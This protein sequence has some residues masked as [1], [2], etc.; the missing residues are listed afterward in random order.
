MAHLQ[1]LAP[2]FILTI[3]NSDRDIPLSSASASLKKLLRYVA[4]FFFY[5]LLATIATYPLILKAAD[6]VFGQ[7][8]PMLNIWAMAWVNHQLPQDAWHLFG[9]NVFYPYPRT[10]AFS[11]HLFV[12]ALMASPWIAVTGNPVLAYN[13]VA[14]LTL[15]LAGLGMYLF[16]RELTNHPVA[17]FVGGLLY[18][19]STWNINELSRIQ[20][21]SNQWFPFLLWALVRFFRQPGQK[22]AF[23]AGLASVLQALSCMYWALYLP[24]VVLPALV[25]LQWRHDLPWR[26][27]LPLGWNL[28]GAALLTAL[29][30]IPYVQN[31]RTFEFTRDP[32][33]PVP[34]D[35]Y[36]QVNRENFLYQ[37]VLGTARV[38]E[39]AA[40]FLGFMAMLLG[41]VGLFAKGASPDNGVRLYRPLFIV[42]IVAGF[43]LSLGHEIRWGN[44]RIAPGPYAAL[45][46]WVPGFRN[47]R[48]PERF[49]IL[50]L[51]G[52]APMVASALTLLP[53]NLSRMGVPLLGGFLFLEHLSVPLDLTHL[54]TGDAMPSVYRWI[55]EDHDIGV[56]A[57]VPSTRYLGERWDMDGMYYSTVHWRRTLQGW[58]SFNPP[59]FNTI[60]WRMFHFP[61]EET[62][63]LLEKLGVDAIVVRPEADDSLRQSNERWTRIGPFPEGHVVLR[64]KRSAGM[65]F[66]PPEDSR[67]PLVNLDPGAWRLRSSPPGPTEQ[68]IDRNLKTS[69]STV[70]HQ[71]EHHYFAVHFSSLRKPRLLTMRAPTQYG[72]PMRFE[73]LGLLEDRTWTRLPFDRAS[74]YDRFF[75][76]LLY[77]PSAARLEVELDAPPVWEILIRITETDAFQMPWAIRELRI[78]EGA[79]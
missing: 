2:K 35:R 54:P 9:G 27:L 30:A 4:P 71:K 77:E 46:E 25:V 28:A 72:F 8:G 15:A 13:M 43:F 42:F 62:V 59:I 56:I 60:R 63:T 29:F 67:S 66:R 44:H 38:N 57:E 68:A 74:A 32:P 45:Y 79:E 23:M 34:I 24:F 75:A 61:E 36:L 64:L 26:K 6:H 76:Q 11:E 12:P 18:A 7:G 19:Y 69:W 52:L 65:K 14:F 22:T 17:S 37:N 16:C 47:V 53:R 78:F 31:S 10:L 40:H 33:N 3:F 49:S 39:N 48:Y 55:A 20:I 73:I 5:F 70:G 51:L 1:Y 41:T 50:L 21:L 58:S